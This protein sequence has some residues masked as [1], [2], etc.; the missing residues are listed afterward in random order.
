MRRGLSVAWLM[1]AVAIMALHAAF[2]GSYLRG[3]SLLGLPGILDIGLLPGLSIVATVA[4]GA[5]RRSRRPGP[6]TLGFVATGL[7]AIL[8]YV[9]CCLAIPEMVAQPLLAYLNEVEPRF[10]DADRAETY[11]L[12]LL[13]SGWVVGWWPP[14][15]AILGGLLFRAWRGDSPG[16]RGA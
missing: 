5:T 10:F 9:A 14:V 15:A 6:F 12:S 4:F 13:I 11:A 7:L 8:G 2:L 16:G 1:F 3:R